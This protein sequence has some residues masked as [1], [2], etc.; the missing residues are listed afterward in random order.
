MF[1][2]WCF[3]GTARTEA[4]VYEKLEVRGRPVF[5]LDIYKILRKELLKPR[6]NWKKAGKKGVGLIEFGLMS[7]LWYRGAETATEAVPAGL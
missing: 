2:R 5:D 7:S 1:D 4:E 6:A 3:L